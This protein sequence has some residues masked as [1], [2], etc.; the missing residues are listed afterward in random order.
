[1]LF[2]TPGL[3]Q[4]ISGVIVYDETLR[5]SCEDGVPLVRRLQDQGIMVGIKVDRGL[6]VIPGTEGETSTQGLDGLGDRC[7]EYYKMGAR[8]AK[9]RAI[10]KISST[11]P[12][13]RA[14][15]ENSW[16]LAR[17]G[18]IC[19][20]NG[21][22]PI[23]EPEVLMD[24]NHDIEKAAQVTEHVQATVYKAMHE[25]GLLLEGTLLKPNMVS[26]GSENLTK[27]TEMDIAAYTIRTLQRTVPVAVTSSL[28]S[29]VSH[30]SAI[31]L[32]LLSC[33]R[34]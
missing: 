23:I 14:V 25:Q 1:M 33:S 19:Q 31:P 21:L 32:P 2:S 13:E 17:Y 11:T 9:W 10:Y 15:Q 29:H 20:E 12:S 4:Y 8:F 24:G 30:L 22:V 3:A 5:S 28:T 18:A 7:A 34:A 6:A 16:A 27:L 26:G